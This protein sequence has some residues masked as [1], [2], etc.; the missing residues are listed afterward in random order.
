MN[1]AD[2]CSI[3]QLARMN[4]VSISGHAL[5]RIIERKISLEDAHDI[6]RSK[7]NC[8]I[9]RQAA[10]T[11]VGKEHKD[12]R[13]LVYD[14]TVNPDII[15][16]CAVSFYGPNQL[17]EISIVIAERVDN[18]KWNRQYDKEPPLVRK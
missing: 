3:R 11:T 17:P 15:V 14:K 12:P 2:L 7:N 1:D 13:Y 4:R 5:E 18:R 6:L 9:E 16:V 10:S 8:I